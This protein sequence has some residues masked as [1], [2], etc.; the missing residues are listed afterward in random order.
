MENLISEEHLRMAANR[1]SELYVTHLEQNYDPSNQHIFSVEFERKIERLKYRADHPF[2]YHTIRRIASIILAILVSGSV[3]LT[4]NVE[5]RAAFVGWVK[6]IYEVFFV[7]H[8][9][10]ELD[11]TEGPDNYEPNWLP[12]GYTKVN[13]FDT[14]SRISIIYQ[15]ESGLFLKLN[16]FY[17][18]SETDA[19]VDGEGGEMTS[20]KI[21]DFDADLLLSHNPTVANSITWID[22]H[23]RAFFISAYLDE[24]DLIK[25]ANSIY[26]K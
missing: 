7:Y 15:N 16:Y 1:A 19:F 6:E 3:Y 14:G 21:N 4:V 9:S 26:K 23:E 22:D 2:V 5:A 13:E 20:I 17:N 25:L 10:G 18:P 12:D 8:F 11:I 24:R